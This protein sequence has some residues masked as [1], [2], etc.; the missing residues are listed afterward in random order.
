MIMNR[1]RSKRI[2]YLGNRDT[3][4][5]TGKVMDIVGSGSVVAY[6]PLSELS[7]SVADNLEG[8]AARDGAYT[9]VTLGQ[10]GIGDGGTCPLFDGINDYVSVILASGVFPLAEGTFMIWA[11][12][13]DASVWTDATYRHAF[14]AEYSSKNVSNIHKLSNNN[15]LLWYRKANDNLDSRQAGYTDVDWMFLLYTFSVANNQFIAYKDGVQVGAIVTDVAARVE[16]ATGTF[17]GSK[18]ASAY[19]WYG[20]LAH[21]L[22]ANRPLVAAEALEL[23]KV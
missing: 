9:G 21:A 10:P 14:T 6:W 8:T 2:I 16:G 3:A 19:F 5:Y 22:V 1:T 12:V 17:I 18:N 11:K 13:Y 23:S 4:K 20:W 15:Q 7:G